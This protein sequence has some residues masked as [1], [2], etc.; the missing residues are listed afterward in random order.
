MRTHLSIALQPT[1]PS[2]RACSVTAVVDAAFGQQSS[3][4]STESPVDGHD[5]IACTFDVEGNTSGLPRRSNPLGLSSVHIEAQE[6][7]HKPS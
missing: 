5:E 3:R 4:P 2:A 7:A 1:A 6:G